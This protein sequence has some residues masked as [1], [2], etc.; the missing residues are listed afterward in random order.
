MINQMPEPSPLKRASEFLR[1]SILSLI[2]EENLLSK[3]DSL[4]EKYK[5]EH[6]GEPPL[7]L[8]SSSD[9]SKEIVNSIK[10]ANNF[11]ADHIV[12]TYKGIKLTHHPGQVSGK[13]YVSN[14]LPET[15]S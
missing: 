7:Y 12:T 15:G 14:E 11:P 8:V 1:Y 9:E 2:M 6:K 5:R 3:I 13:M 4:I 10:A